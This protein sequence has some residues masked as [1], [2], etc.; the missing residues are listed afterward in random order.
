MS[1]DKDKAKA[2]GIGSV[3]I[4]AIVAGKTNEEALAAVS[5]AHPGAKTGMASINWYRNKLRAEGAKLKGSSKPVPTSRE[6]AAAAKKTAGGEYKK[7]TTK[8]QAAKKP[9]AKKKT[10]VE[11]DPLLA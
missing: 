7:P 11:V 3:A 8:K 6:L 1:K 2:P 9:T 10:K 5:A 4:E